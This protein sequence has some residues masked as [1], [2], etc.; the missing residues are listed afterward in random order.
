VRYLLVGLGNIGRKRL[1]LLGERCIATADP[2]V[3]AADFVSVEACPVEAY[4]A[5]VLA[6]PNDAKPALLDYFL[7]RGKHVLVEKPLLFPDEESARRLEALAGEHAASW[8]TSYNHRFEPL[9]RSLK[10]RLD[11]RCI[12]TIYHARFF[13]GNGT[14]RNVAG[15]WRDSGLGALE[16]LGP[17]LLDLSGY[18]LGCRGQCFEPLVMSRHELASFDHCVVASRDRHVMLEVSFVSWKNTFSVDVVGEHGSLHLAGLAKWGPAELVARRR[19]FPSGP[20]LEERE[21]DDSG[22]DT[23]WERDLRHFEDI[24]AAGRTSLDNDWWISSTLRALAE[25]RDGRA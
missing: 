21:H 15:T 2:F 22:V 25:A 18:L 4:D 12:G 16:D 19:V 5:V 23:T 17:H 11:E 14:A 9:I 3:G 7:R 6:V 24:S 8:Y 20:P 13:Y 10:R 1:D